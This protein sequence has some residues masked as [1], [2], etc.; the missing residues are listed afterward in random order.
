MRHLTA[1]FQLPVLACGV[2]GTANS[3]F[4]AGISSCSTHLSQM[5]SLHYGIRHRRASLL[6]STVTKHYQQGSVM[7]H[8]ALSLADVSGFVQR[9]VRWCVRFVHRTAC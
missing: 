6:T 7:P 9:T 2:S 8:T 5:I 4:S 3:H 1:R